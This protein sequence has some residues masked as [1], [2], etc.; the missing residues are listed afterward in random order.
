MKSAG[1]IETGPDMMTRNEGLLF[2]LSRKV[3]VGKAG[4][5]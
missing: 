4:Q 5:F 2:F 1:N 3:G